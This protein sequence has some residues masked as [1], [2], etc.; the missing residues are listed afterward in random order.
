MSLYIDA[1]KMDKLHK[2]PASILRHIDQC[3]A[4]HTKALDMY[5]ILGDQDY[6]K[7]GAHPTLDKEVTVFN[8]RRLFLRIAA[9]AA[10]LALAFFF[11]QRSAEVLPDKGD[12]VVEDPQEE[13]IPNVEEPASTLP[14]EDKTKPESDKKA[15]VG[16]I[17]NQ[18]PQ[19]VLP[20][21]ESDTKSAKP[22]DDRVRYAANFVPSEHW[23]SMVNE[24]VR[25]D[26][27]EAKKPV[28]SAVFKFGNTIPFQWSTDN[29]KGLQL[30]LLNNRGEEIKTIALSGIELLWKEQLTPGRY[31]WKVES[32]DDLLYVGR[33][34][35]AN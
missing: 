14:L 32:A 27:F 30:I 4:C 22:V 5:T 10:M 7:S 6:N 24:T 23:E 12:V 8:K 26:G 20:K 28:T 25:G 21:G 18:V 34:E 15:P 9:A 31:Y 29:V 35:V 2:V 17:V 16:N 3:D 1:L 13:V 19:A 33:F 11:Y